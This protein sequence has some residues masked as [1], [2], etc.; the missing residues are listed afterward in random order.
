ME[1]IRPQRNT[2]EDAFYYFLDFLWGNRVGVLMVLKHN[3]FLTRIARCK[4]SLK[5]LNGH[6][7]K[8]T[9]FL[10]CALHI[11]NPWW[12]SIGSG[13]VIVPHRPH[14]LFASPNTCII[15]TRFHDKCPWPFVVVPVTIFTIF[16]HKSSIVIYPGSHRPWKVSLCSP[17]II[18]IV[19]FPARLS[20]RLTCGYTA[21]QYR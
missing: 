6:E 1:E 15:V 14:R 10:L 16:I 5:W 4:S 3:L 21:E 13:P 11:P 12:G 18:E 9:I 2:E 20:C 17:V 8:I 19:A 7:K